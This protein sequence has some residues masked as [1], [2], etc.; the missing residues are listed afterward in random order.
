[1]GSKILLPYKS[2]WYNLASR[3][4]GNILE[5]LELARK[6]V[7]A[8]SEKQ[9]SNIVL[10]DVR[11]LCTFTDFFV[12]CSAES[13]RQLNSIA[14]E[15]EGVLKKEGVKPHHR[16]GTTDSGWYLLDYTD[17]IVH[18]FSAQEREFYALEELWSDAKVVLRIQ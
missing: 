14:D 17:V 8:A 12:I 11:E 3:G 16:E 6:A 13:S 5:G 10:L 18:I 7:D 9:A 2:L 4:G 15:I 1:M